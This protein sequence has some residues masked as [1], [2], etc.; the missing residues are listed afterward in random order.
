M[1]MGLTDTYLSL[2]PT[3]HSKDGTMRPE[4][5]AFLM[6][7]IIETAAGLSFILHP[8]GQLPGC[9]PTAK[10]ILRQYGGLLLA[11][12]MACLVVVIDSSL[13]STTMRLLAVAL[14]S[15]HIWPCYRALIRIQTETRHRAKEASV[16]GGPPVHLL[17]H[18]VCLSLFVHT[19]IFET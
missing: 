17:V 7:A 15:Y 5:L 18:A 10:L 2:S 4:K 1:L 14:G 8:E 11:S 16:L 9:T 3:R 19:A 13:D 6:H 12:S